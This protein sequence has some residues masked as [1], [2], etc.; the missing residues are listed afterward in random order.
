MSDI[1][2]VIYENRVFKPPGKVRGENNS[3]D[4]K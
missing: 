4:Q 1:I 2:K 3:G